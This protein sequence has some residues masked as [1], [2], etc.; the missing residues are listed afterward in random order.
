M[1]S[2]RRSSQLKVATFSPYPLTPETPD[3]VAQFVLGIQ[4]HL[5]RLGCDTELVGPKA[6]KSFRNDADYTFGRTP[7]RFTHHGTNHPIPVS[8][9]Q[10]PAKRMLE[11][12]LFDN[13]NDQ[14]PDFVFDFHEPLLLGHYAHPII[15]AMPRRQDGKSIPTTIAHHHAQIEGSSLALRTALYFAKMRLL[16]LEGGRVRRT[17]GYANTI[18]DVFDG[19]IAVSHATA[20]TWSIP[21]PGNYEV[22]PNGF[23]TTKLT[24]DGPVIEEWKQDGKQTIFFAGRHDERKGLIYLIE[25]FAL[26]KQERGDIKLKIA[27]Y[28]SQTE[29]LQKLVQELGLED[30]DF[31]GVL[32][33]EDLEKAYRS[34]DVVVCPSIGGEG[35][36]RV[37]AEALSCAALVVASDIN[38]Y[39]EATGGNQPF[40]R[41]AKPED[42]YDLAR[43]INEVI[44]LPDE[45]KKRLGK[46]GRQHVVSNF[47]WENVAKRTFN[48]YLTCLENH[49]KAADEDWVKVEQAR[50]KEHIIFQKAKT[51]FDRATHLMKR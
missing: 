21:F 49:G 25:A 2:E 9:R 3:G 48:Y 35:F 23:D 45:E 7:F 31:L 36:G 20:A 41:L 30:V 29:D 51:I 8:L 13:N 28:G 37:I 15:S 50:L 1:S 39:R 14:N 11:T 5:K 27:G 10:A 43:V 46:E 38:G 44:N 4:P 34:V 17:Q 40:A 22:I 42:P 26:L 6:D 33:R 19:R 18:M 24:P 16:K 32:P 47:D 12:I